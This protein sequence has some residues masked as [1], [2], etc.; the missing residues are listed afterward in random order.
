M[1]TYTMT[2]VSGDIVD[3]PFDTESYNK[4]IYST[5]TE[6]LSKQEFELADFNRSGTFALNN[7][8]SYLDAP[9]RLNS[10]VE[11]RVKCD[12]SVL[13]SREAIY[14]RC[15]SALKLNEV[16]LQRIKCLSNL[17]LGPKCIL[18]FD[19]KAAV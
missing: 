6:K 8:L 17:P 2:F 5:I 12:I 3:L 19:M 16:L 18:C 10:V 11:V 15:L 4:I 14:A 13:K 9:Y 7:S 1:Y